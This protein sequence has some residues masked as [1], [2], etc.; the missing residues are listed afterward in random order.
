MSGADPHI[1]DA[2]NEF[3]QI[4]RLLR[5]LTDGAPEALKLQ[6]D[7]AVLPGRPGYDLVVTKD[8]IVAGVH[9]L[10]GDP[11][12]AVARKLLRVNLSDLAAMGAEPYAYFLAVSWPHGLGWDERERFAA[13][14][15][16]DQS[17]F[18][19]VLLGGDTVSTPGPLTA[20]ATLLGWV[21]AGT[22]VT[23]AGAKPGDRVMVTGTIGDGG[24]GLRAA[25]GALPGVSEADLQWLEGR[26]RLT[27]PRLGLA[28]AL[29]RHAHAAADVSDG[30][31]A[32]AGHIARASGVGVTLRLEDLPLSPAAVA[33]LDQQSDRTVALAALAT[34][35]D[36]YEIVCAVPPEAEEDLIAAASD[37]GIALASIGEV[38]AGQGVTVLH[39]DRP[40]TLTSLGWRH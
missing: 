36:D 20:S 23:R 16:H 13:G 11:M 25:R 5:P 32:D 33:W 39:R 22:A 21:P 15:R 30:L 29:R 8:A 9:F 4:E 10:A 35:G 1:N 7:A 3:D 40:V 26:Y 24:L 2:V 14:L 37:A 6:D 38:T 17:G 12:D 28:A 34:G 19:L 31:A 27:S 18:G